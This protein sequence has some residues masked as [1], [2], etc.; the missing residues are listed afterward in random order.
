VSA[1]LS[2]A[3]VSVVSRGQHWNYLAGTIGPLQ[4][5]MFETPGR[6]FF[7]GSYDGGIRPMSVKLDLD[8]QQLV[9]VAAPTALYLRTRPW[10]RISVIN[11]SAVL[12]T[13]FFLVVSMNREFMSCLTL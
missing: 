1:T 8:P 9:Y 2:A 11:N 6:A 7:L 5:Q 4:E 10:K 12:T 3:G 13:R